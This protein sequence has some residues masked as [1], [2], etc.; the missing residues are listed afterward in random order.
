MIGVLLAAALL[1]GATDKQPEGYRVTGYESKTH[2]W[3]IIR[4]GTFDGGFQTKRLIVVCQLFV[5]ANGKRTVGPDACDLRVGQFM[6]PHF[7]PVAGSPYLDIVEFPDSLVITE[8]PDVNSAVHEF[9][10]IK[11]IKLLSH[12]P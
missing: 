12:N 10:H 8:G 9:F 6:V 1:I 4:T 7:L 2:E 5:A 3:T 11:K